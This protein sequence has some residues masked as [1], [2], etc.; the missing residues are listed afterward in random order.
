MKLQAHLMVTVLPFLAVTVL[1]LSLGLTWYSKQTVLEQA[2]QDGQLLASVLGRSIEVSQNVEQASEEL[3][4]RDL[5]TSATILAHFIAVAEQ[6]RLP[7][8]AITQ[9]LTSMVTADNLSEIWITDSAGKAYL[10]TVPGDDFVFSPDPLRQP[11]ASAFWPLLNARTPSMVAQDLKPRETDGRPF[12]YV[13]VS[14]VDRPRI[15]QVGMD[16]HML[17]RMRESLGVQELLEHVAEEE[18]LQQIWVVN[19]SLDIVEY[20]EKSHGH[21]QPDP[22]SQGDRDMLNEAMASGKALSRIESNHI[23]VAAPLEWAPDSDEAQLDDFI[24]HPPHAT[25]DGAKQFNR[26]AI[27]LYMSND[28]LDHLIMKETAFATATAVVCLLLA[29]LLLMAY[30]R[31]L[32]KP[33][34]TAVDVAERV[35]AGDLSVDLASDGNDEISVLINA[36]GQM[37]SYLNSL[38]GQVKRSTGDLI[39][40]AN[41][42]SAM[43]SIQSEG[44]NNLGTTSHDIAAATTEISVTSE[45]LLKNMDSI[46]EVANHTAA[47]ANSGQVSLGEMKGSIG[48]LSHATHAISERLGLISER[49]NTISTVT[50]TI[51]KIADQTNILSLNASIEAEKAGEYGQGFAVLAREIRRLADQTA[52]ATLGIRQMIK[53][54]QDAVTSGVMEMDKFSDQVQQSVADTHDISLRFADI[55]HE[56]QALLPRFDAVHDGMRSQSTGARQ[57]RDAM[58]PLTKSVRASIQSLDETTAATRKLEAAIH[59]LSSEISAFKLR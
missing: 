37:V 3:I 9:R 8:P 58:M 52:V 6:C 42:L 7:R 30:T 41:S 51:S 44:I 33:I 13:G 49:A 17:T 50:T 48:Q 14:G 18:S 38:I 22:L 15:V 16:G 21:I 28:L 55:I 59:D 35:A 26:S 54:M 45:A 31:R 40:T 24:D 11:Q 23:T 43:A 57:I 29:A 25:D 1:S 20:A 46:T 12:K 32:V 56:V 34:R 27:L 5:A 19:R 36:L 10:H 39:A 53:E 2:R 4:S 47:L